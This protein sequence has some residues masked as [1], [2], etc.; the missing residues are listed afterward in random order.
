MDHTDDVILRIERVNAAAGRQA[1]R[2]D[3]RGRVR[4]RI[5]VYLSLARRILKAIDTD[6]DCADIDAWM[7]GVFRDVLGKREGVEW[8]YT[9]LAAK[10]YNIGGE[11]ADALR[12]GDKDRAHRLADALRSGL[13]SNPDH[14][15]EWARETLGDGWRWCDDESGR[16]PE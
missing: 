15:Q 16:R 8:R 9:T 4:M 7:C 12:A 10:V 14:V 2:I 13:W 1:V 11:L 5:R 3:E 6:A